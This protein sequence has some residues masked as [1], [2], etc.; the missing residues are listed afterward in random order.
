VAT[1]L[2]ILLFLSGFLRNKRA[3]LASTVLFSSGLVFS[4]LHQRWQ[5]EYAILMAF[6]VALVYGSAISDSLGFLKATVAARVEL[7]VSLLLCSLMIFSARQGKGNFIEYYEREARVTASVSTLF[8]Q[9]DSTLPEGHV[10]EIEKVE[11]EFFPSPALARYLR[12]ALRL[13][14]PGR[15]YFWHESQ[16]NTVESMARES[17]DGPFAKAWVPTVDSIVKIRCDDSGCAVV[18]N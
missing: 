13:A 1:W 17:M 12:F 14:A 7:V 5:P 15:T 8:A 3:A 18:K 11:G 4:I 2:T 10:I 16:F 9:L 6:G